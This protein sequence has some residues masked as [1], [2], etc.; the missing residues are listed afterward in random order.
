M[1]YVERY[2]P[3]GRISG[4]SVF[5]V[6]SKWIWYPQATAGQIQVT[7]QKEH[8]VDNDKGRIHSEDIEW[9]SSFRRRSEKVDESQ[10]SLEAQERM[11]HVTKQGRMESHMK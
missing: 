5:N 11:P 7:I 6:E 10:L 4:L 9:G 2:V 8:P 3:C 1:T